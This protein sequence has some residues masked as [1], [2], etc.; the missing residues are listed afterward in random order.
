VN[1]L[2]NRNI[3]TEISGNFSVQKVAMGDEHTLILT[4]DGKVYSF[5]RNTVRPFI[6]HSLVGKSWGWNNN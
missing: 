3:F 6:I 4:L 2:T 5:G 1:D